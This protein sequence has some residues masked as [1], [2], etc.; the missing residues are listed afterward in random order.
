MATKEERDAK[1]CLAE[2]EAVFKKYRFMYSA[3]PA[4]VPRQDGSWGIVVNVGIQRVPESR[5]K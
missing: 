2:V 3:V 4:L 1:K 5:S